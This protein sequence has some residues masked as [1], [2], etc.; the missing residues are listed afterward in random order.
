MNRFLY[1]FLFLVAA[2]FTISAQDET[3]SGREP[4]WRRQALHLSIESR[5]VGAQGEVI[6]SEANTKVTMPGTPVGV[7][8]LGSNVVVSAQFT[9]FIR[10]D[11][12]VLVAQG[13]IWIAD[14]DDVINYYT[15]IQTIPMEFGEQIYFFPLGS[16]THL[17]PSIEIVITVNSNESINQR[18]NF[19]N[20]E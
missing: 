5:V 19:A 20:R 2:N 9:P 16:A 11:G 7:Q 1:L 18:R 8:M 6:W 13:Q 17:I 4:G 10:P 15:S 14:P 12:N 3:A